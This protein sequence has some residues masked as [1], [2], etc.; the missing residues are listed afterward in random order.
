MFFRKTFAVAPHQ[1]GYLF[2]ENRLDRKLA[3]GIYPI[4]DWKNR[5]ALATIP[6]QLFQATIT[7]QEVLTRD[8]IALR[9]SFMVE[10]DIA[11]PDRFVAQYNVLTPHFTPRFQAQ[12]IVHQ[13]CQVQLRE[14]I[15]QLEVD[16]LSEQHTRIANAIPDTLHQQLAE[17]GIVLH[18]RL[19][20]DITFPRHIQQLFAQKL[21]ARIRAETDLQHART[22]VAAA[23]A[24]KN[25]AALMQDNENLKF[26]QLLETM[27]KIAS[28][29]NHTFVLSDTISRV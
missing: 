23:R 7:N 10:F 14:V 29:G 12:E 24:L 13:Y 8:A 28:K 26:I 20:K 16:E 19:L 18:Q 5:Y 25:A 1:V 4:I 22:A 21:E 17:Y 3:P 27:T 9:F 11:D 6:T 2:Y 15:R